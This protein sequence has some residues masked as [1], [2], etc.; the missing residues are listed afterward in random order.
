[1]TR[2]LTFLL[3]AIIT[4]ARPASAGGPWEGKWQVAWPN[5]GG[6]I[7]LTQQD[8][9]VTGTYGD[10]FGRVEARAQG[11][12]ITGQLVQQ[13]SS[14]SFTAML[15]PDGASFSGHTE[16]GNWLS[17]VRVAGTGGAVQP[18]LVDLSTPRSVIRSFLK[19]GN[20]ARGS[21]PQA[22]AWAVETI[23]F[24]NFPEWASLETR[25]AAA[26]ELFEAVDLATF[27]LSI[28]P[29]ITDAPT[30]TLP[31]DAPRWGRAHQA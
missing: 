20:L 15:G 19:A 18:P 21:E 24:G 3:F 23:D 17:G 1:M 27:S 26:E 29:E 6:F 11:L 2:L 9:A 12:L 7:V 22:I 8:A 14:E 5:G 13:R 4:M 31:F 10:G 16:T 28:V 30:L 25:P